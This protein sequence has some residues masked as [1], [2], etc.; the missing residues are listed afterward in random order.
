[1]DLFRALSKAQSAT[2]ALMES[3]KCF[4][5]EEGISKEISSQLDY[6]FDL[7]GLL[8]LKIGEM[9]QMQKDYREQIQRESLS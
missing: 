3:F 6:A 7:C 4:E 5:E 9:N 8:M 1:M 2:S